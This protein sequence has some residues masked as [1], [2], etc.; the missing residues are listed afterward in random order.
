MIARLVEHCNGIAEVMGLNLIQACMFQ[1]LISRL[2]RRRGKYEAQKLSTC[3][4]T[5]FRCKFLSIFPIFH[6]MWS[7]CR[8]TKTFVA[9]SRARV[10]FEQQML[11]LLLGLHETHKLSRNKFARALQI[12]QSARRISLTRNKC[13]CCG[14][15]SSSKV[16]NAK[17]RPNPATKQC[18]TTS[19]GFL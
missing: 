15:S 4:A 14:S 17:H 10:Y 6:L 18:C 19:W 8:A 1:A 9:K 13:F 5:L 12:N 11:A 2:L 16:K 7:T 3:P